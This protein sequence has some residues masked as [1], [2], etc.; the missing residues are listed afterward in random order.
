MVPEATLVETEHGLVPRGEGWFV[1]NARDAAW[2]RSERN[3]E[4]CAFEGDVRFSQLGFNLN[5][6]QPAS[7]SRSTTPRRRRRGSSCSPA[8]PC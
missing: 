6:L 8:R 1:L 2:E 3:G 5:V 4:W 7:R